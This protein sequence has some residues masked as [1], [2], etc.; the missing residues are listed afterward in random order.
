[1][2][3]EKNNESV[4]IGFLFVF[5]PV[6]FLIIGNQV[7]PSEYYRSPPSW[8]NIPLFFGLLLLFAGFFIKDRI[9]NILRISGWLVFSFYWATQPLKLYSTEGGDIFNAVVCGIGVFVLCYIAY[10]EWLS[11]VRKKDISCLKWL[12]GASAFAGIIYFGI[13]RIVIDPWNL[14][15]IFTTI[16]IPKIDL[17]MWLTQ[18]VAEQSAAVLSIFTDGVSISDVNIYMDGAYVVTIIFACTGIQALVIFVGMI[19]AIPKI[20]MKRRVIGLFVTVVPVYILNLFRNALVAFLFGKDITSF[21]MAHN[22]IA[23]AGSLITL[24]I[25][26]L[27]VIKIVPE[28]FDEIICL[29]NL[30]KRNGPLEKVAGTF[31]RGKKQK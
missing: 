19:G 22:V 17:E 20:K 11:F 14:N 26:L 29:T 21:N 31:F 15:M 13:E 12:A 5:I 9:G 4:I 2:M 23:K 27:I 16:N 24:I 28:I 7:F 30:Y 18:R 1:M 3:Q 10:H 8:L 25:L 6:V